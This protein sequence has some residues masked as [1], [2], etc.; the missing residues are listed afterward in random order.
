LPSKSFPHNNKN[1]I[2]GKKEF[3]ILNYSKNLSRSI[4]DKF[5]HLYK[6]PKDSSLKDEKNHSDRKLLELNSINQKIIIDPKNTSIIGKNINND[7]DN[8]NIE[9]ITINRQQNNDEILSNEKIDLFLKEKKFKKKQ[10]LLI[11]FSEL[12]ILKFLFCCK[13][14]K[15][16]DFLKQQEFFTQ[17]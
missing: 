1:K 12:G 14:F 13:R 9:N 10:T 4:N 11:K 16:A 3:K 15:Y 6:N 8:L 17:E 5:P 7:K 2:I